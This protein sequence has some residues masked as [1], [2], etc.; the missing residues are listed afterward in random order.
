MPTVAFSNTAS[1]SRSVRCRS[2]AARRCGLTSSTIQIVPWWVA[3]LS[4]AL[5]IRRAHSRVPLRRQSSSSV[6]K[7]SPRDST[8]PAARLTAV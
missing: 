5:A 6:W 7:S 8:G 4:T 1:S 3:V 2:S